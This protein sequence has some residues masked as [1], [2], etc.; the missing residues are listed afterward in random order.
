MTDTP[1]IMAARAVLEANLIALNAHDE[2]ALADTFHFPHYRL[3][4]GRMKIWDT[5]DAYFAD[6]R[7]R[8]GKGWGYTE[9]GEVTPVQ[10]GPDKVHLC[11]RVD[12][13]RADGTMLSS[14]QS[15]WVIARLNA[16]WAAQLR[17]S[18]AQDSMNSRLT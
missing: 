10:S 13:F 12:R 18:F 9:W 15:L 7:A 8:A 4:E 6:F 14:F 5:P 17:S 1:E 2:V 11:V 3:S 16:K